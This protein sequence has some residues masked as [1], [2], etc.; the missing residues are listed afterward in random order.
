MSMITLNAPPLEVSP[1]V[2]RYVRERELEPY[3]PALVAILRRL[4]AD[5]TRFDVEVHH[6]P[7]IEGLS[8]LLFEVEVPWDSFEQVQTAL[9]IWHRETFALCPATLI[10]AFTLS[11]WRR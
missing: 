7:E 6:D 4:F 9:D 5:A 3:F 10:T 2:H 8:W 11:V 1:E